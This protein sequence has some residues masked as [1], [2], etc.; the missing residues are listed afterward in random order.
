MM[1]RVL[2]GIKVRAGRMSARPKV[3]PPVF[4]GDG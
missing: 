3:R 2:K 1:R 4:V